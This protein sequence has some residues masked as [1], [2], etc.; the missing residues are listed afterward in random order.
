MIVQLTGKVIECGPL[1][2]VLETYGVGYEVNIP[3]TTA[4]VIPNTGGTVTLYIQS[5]YREESQ[6]LYGFSTKEDR[7][8]FKLLVEKVSGIG[9]KIALSIMSKLSVSVLNNAISGS[10]VAL[11]SQCPGIGKKTAERLVIELR[12]K[13]FPAHALTIDPSI[14]ANGG[15][16]GSSQTDAV[17]ALI[18]LG[19]KPADADKAIRKALAKSKPQVSTEELIKVALG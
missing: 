10:D 18:A 7:D 11:L 9:P 4:E 17:A 3:L 6:S 2:V 1:R 15:N 12:D 16:Q 19:Y 8:F 13:I 5:I 14:G